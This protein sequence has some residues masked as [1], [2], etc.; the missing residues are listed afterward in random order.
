[1]LLW[2][3]YFTHLN[4]MVKFYLESSAFE[5]CLSVDQVVVSLTNIILHKR[6]RSLKPVSLGSSTP[7]CCNWIF[8]FPCASIPSHI[9]SPVSLLYLPS[10]LFKSLFSW[11]SQ[12]CLVIFMHLFQK[13][14][15]RVCFVYLMPF[16][17]PVTLR[18]FPYCCVFSTPIEQSLKQP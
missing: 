13:I 6:A 2:V 9:S 14:I 15:S 5:P 17:V 3:M 11:V 12:F 18:S 10:P 1:M 4:N 8:H 7:F 16:W